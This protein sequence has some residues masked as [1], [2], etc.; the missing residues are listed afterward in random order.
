[1][2]RRRLLIATAVI[3]S[4]ILAACSDMTA[5]KNVCPVVN[6]SQTC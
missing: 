4:A 6:G 2:I 5:P 3:A 1:M